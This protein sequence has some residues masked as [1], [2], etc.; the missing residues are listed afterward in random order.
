MVDTVSRCSRENNN[1]K[2]DPIGFLLSLW[3]L[4]PLSRNHKISFPLNRHYD[5]VFGVLFRWVRLH[6]ASTNRYSLVFRRHIR[7][8]RSIATTNDTRNNAN[9]LAT[10]RCDQ[11]QECVAQCTVDANRMIEIFAL[12]TF[13]YMFVHS[14]AGPA[15]KRIYFM[16]CFALNRRSAGDI[17]PYTKMIL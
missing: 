10:G 8:H 9:I 11:R 4:F 14:T 1:E 17:K 16:W 2:G 15:T 13:T 5:V 3:L 6:C 7:A 12:R